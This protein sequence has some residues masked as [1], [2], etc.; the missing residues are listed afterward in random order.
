MLKK[1]ILQFFLFI[2][3]VSAIGQVFDFKLLNQENGLPSSVI[4]V[5]YQDSRDLTWIG[6]QGGLVKFDGV[7]FETYNRNN[8]LL[9][10]DVSDIVEDSNKNLLI[11]TQ[12]GGIYI[13]DGQSF[14]N[15]FNVSKNNITSKRVFKIIKTNSG[16][17]GISENEIF[18][19]S[20]DY[21]YKLISKIDFRFDTVNSFFEISKNVYVVATEKGIFECKNNIINKLFSDVITGNT[22]ACKDLDNNVRIGT[23]KAE[24][25]TVSNN[26]LSAPEIIKTNN[27][28]LF[29]INHLFVAK[30]GN[31]WM[32]S[33][34]EDGI[35][36]NAEGYISFFDGKNGFDGRDVSL[37]FQDKLKDLYIGT[38]GSGLFK[39]KA[40]N[41]LGFGNTK[42][43]NSSKIF[44]II[45]QKED[46]YF[47]DNEK[48]ILKFTSASDG[49]LSLLKIILVK[50][51]YASLLNSKNEIIFSTST[52]LIIFNKNSIKNITLNKQLKVDEISIKSIFEDKKHRYFIATQSQGLIILDKNFKILQRFTKKNIPILGNNVSTINEV[53][54]NKWY[55]GSSMGVFLLKEKDNKF[56]YSKIIINDDIKIGTQ[57]SFGNFWF[58]GNMKLHSITKNNKKKFYTE[59]SGILSTLIYTL[60][61]NRD[62]E[63]LLGSNLGIAKI[64]VN[65]NAE[66]ESIDNFNPKNG[67]T[68]LETNQNAQFKE[69]ETGNIYFGTSKGIYLSLSRYKTEEIIVPKIEITKIILLNN[70]NVWNT[71]SSNKWIN[72]PAQNYT[73]KA[74]ENHLTFEYKTINNKFSESALYS[75]IL[76]GNEKNWSK[77]SKQN[78]VIF[79]NINSGNYT[80]KVKIVDNLGKQISGIATYNFTIKTPFYFTW[81]FILF[82]IIL[83]FTIINIIFKKTSNYNKDFVKNYS[84]IETSNEQY[85]LYFLFLGISLPIIE[86]LI[87]LGGARQADTLQLNLIVGALLISV[88]LLSRKFKIIFNNFNLFFIGAYILY[89]ITTIIKLI[90][91]PNNIDIILEFVFMFILG[92]NLFKTLKAYWL[93]VFLVFG[94]IISLYTTNC[95]SK[96]T[97]IT[98]IN[99]CFMIA[100][101]NHVRYITNLNS[102]DKFLFA[103][104]IINKGTSL[105]LAVNKAGEVVYCSQTIKQILGYDPLEIMGF[106]YWM[107]TDDSEFTTE[108]YQPSNTLYIRKLK[109]KDGSYKYIQWKDS[110]YSDD[111][112]V[113]VGQDVTERVQIE[114]QYKNLIQNASDIIYELDKH[115]F[116]IFVNNFTAQMLDYAIEDFYHN[117]FTEFIRED[118]K[119]TVIKFYSNFDKNDSNFPTLIFPILT[120]DG[121]NIWLS[122]I[123]SVK[124][125]DLGNLIGF[126]AIARDI[127]QLK[128]NEEIN[129]KRQEKLQKHNEA[130]NTLVS[131]S[132]NEND[133]LLKILQNIL[134]I[135]GKALNI[136]RVSYWENLPDLLNC[137]TEY[138]SEKNRYTSDDHCLKIERPIYFKAINSKKILISNDVFKNPDLQEFYDGYFSEKSIKSMMDI[139]IFLNGEVAGLIS[140]ESLNKQVNWDDYD[141][142]FV[143]SI[144]DVIAITLEKNQRILVEK[145]LA[146]KSELL[147]A[148]TK[149]T[150]KFLI[151]S[152][153]NLIFDEVLST[154]GIATNVDRAYYFENDNKNKTVSQKFEWVSKQKY[155]ELKNPRL[156]NYKFESFDEYMQILEQNKQYNFIVKTIKNST[157]KKTLQDQKILSIITLPIF[158]KNQ[159]HGFIGFD[160]CSKERIWSEDEISIL[161]TLAV[162]ISSSF[163]RNINESMIF[164]SEERFK[165]LANNIPGTVYLSK[166]D[167][168]STKVY[169]N[170]EIE[171][172]TGY[173]K[174]EFL[175]SKVSY[176]DLIHPDDVASV[177][178]KEKE[179]IL[180]KQKIHS[181]YRIIHKNNTIVWVEEFG[182]AI[183]KDGEIAFVEGIFI[184]ITERKEK[185][186]AIQD[187]EI[188]EASNKA[189]SE[190]LANMSH[191]IRTPLN[192]IVGFSNLLHDSKLEKTQKEYINTV[193]QSAHILLEVV[194]DI[195]DFS[196][197]E[198]GKLELEYRKTDLYE[199]VNQI[200][201]IIRFD[202]EQKGI[203]LNLSIQNETPKYVNIDAL[204]LKQVLIN[205]LSNAV[206][207]TN[208]G[209]VQFNVELISQ[210][211]NKAK[212]RFSVKDSGIGIKRNNQDKI[213][214]PFSQEDSSTTRKYG[215]SGLGLTISNNL[216]QLMNSKLELNSDY[217]KG[218]NFYFDLDLAYYEEP[219]IDE[220][221]IEMIEVEFEN[222]SQSN[223]NIVFDKIKKILVVEDNKINMLLAKTLIKNIMPNTIVYEA[224]NGKI[225]LEYYHEF[226]PDLILLDI[227]MP[228]LNGYETTIEIRKLDKKIPIIAL[229]AGTIMGEKEKCIKVGMNDY[230]SKPIIK[231]L[232]EN[233][234]LRWLQ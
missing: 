205:L 30:S 63:I 222:L 230:I 220:I 181:I 4:N 86:V 229:T 102:K 24:L 73:F 48:G 47:F 67:F 151:N 137:V 210:N 32:S 232:F 18:S 53:A 147:A 1:Y 97:M 104:D 121:R 119:E 143:R 200:I 114:N 31:I 95:I 223:R 156:Q 21:S 116:F 144:A 118:Y 154:I 41:F 176:I 10:I 54:A 11:A 98:F 52:G 172:L 84:E 174:L 212:I 196:K 186:K 79:S 40:Q 7:L 45:S 112:Y 26:K 211:T 6:T 170:D 159:L 134:K 178:K 25:F 128:N 157:Y 221:D 103:D 9:N 191:E 122:Q 19:I 36:L 74:N 105:V 80:F 75:Y 185:E 133:T 187:K 145:K 58:A 76:E 198:T 55:I 124:K 209:G 69:A 17:V 183:I 175:E 92:Y 83:V 27:N 126:S 158:V 216:L 206:K 180:K 96:V 193:N 72:L 184:D 94:L 129:K 142:S 123:V 33:N 163:E 204:R 192:A 188:A 91:Y 8:G 189:K 71:N 60:I 167:E 106:S 110:K 3:S 78:Q 22:T 152:N 201:D 44:S 62:S 115:G 173:S 141:I 77:P 146:Y 135:T 109:C 207:F 23:D 219:I 117:H 168:A 125:D 16:I 228:V 203:S 190:F 2:I 171:T 130:L 113:G 34:K 29:P 111:L 153:I 107:L 38:A 28:K 177:L 139:S 182:E 5:M 46:F 233:I 43:L 138:D 35:C 87:E 89:G 37:F 131:T 100:I 20:S 195:L 101:L 39:T 64:S 90:N 120:K 61:G 169:L 155:S 150:N 56:Y 226:K 81:W 59:K 162:N 199:L 68:G 82:T 85:S 197:I 148:I 165:L 179:A 215:G 166:F 12:S 164:E 225:G 88:Y 160:D 65:K 227:Q 202:S 14:T 127:T 136:N 149:I 214:E 140:V 208:I 15:K 231:D 194:N 57:D 161:E 108:N 42:Y 49:E 224:L 217:K 234:L 66:I 213:F 99:I 70:K 93:Y 218:S 13:F 132:Y 51:G 50:N